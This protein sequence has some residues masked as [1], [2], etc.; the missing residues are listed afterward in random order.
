MNYTIFEK[1]YMIHTFPA[2]M[3]QWRTSFK[4]CK[5]CNLFRKL[6]NTFAGNALKFVSWESLHFIVP[7]ILPWL[8]L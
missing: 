5:S 8:A 6:C 4:T 3:Y 2:T 7:V 1:I